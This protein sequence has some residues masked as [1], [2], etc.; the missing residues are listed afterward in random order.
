MMRRVTA[1]KTISDGRLIEGCDVS[2][3]QGDIDWSQVV[4]A[5]KYFAYIKATDGAAHT[6]DHYATNWADAGSA[7]IL[8]GAYHFFRHGVPGVDQAA[9]FLSVAKPTKGDL[10]PALDLEDPPTDQSVAGYLAETA[11]WV[12]AVASAIGGRAPVIYCAPSFWRDTLGEP[13][14]FTSNPLWIAEYT[15]HNPTVPGSWS[16][17]T[18][19]QYAESGTVPGISASVDLDRFQGSMDD[20]KSLLLTGSRAAVRARRMA[21]RKKR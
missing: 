3:H 9:N 12:S 11:S 8:R 20:L 16:R 17:F 15:T 4:S 5:S 2:H 19:W 21:R 7:G 18:F 6:D 13:N 10:P 14:Q 1:R